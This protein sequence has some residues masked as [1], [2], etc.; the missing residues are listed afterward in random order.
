[1]KART[2][3]VHWHIR[4]VLEDVREEKV[5]VGKLFRPARLTVRVLLPV[6]CRLTKACVLNSVKTWT[7]GSRRRKVCDGPRWSKAKTAIPCWAYFGKT[8][9][10]RSTR[11]MKLQVQWYQYMSRR[12]RSA[13]GLSRVLNSPVDEQDCGANGSRRVGR[14]VFRE[15]ARPLRAS[16]VLDVLHRVGV[17]CVREQLPSLFVCGLV[18]G[19]EAEEAAMP[20]KRANSSGRNLCGLSFPSADADTKS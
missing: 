14:P 8:W 4:V 11:S 2:V 18:P 15:E 6:G 7:R 13:C 17:L 9:S 3:K 16:Q 19:S 20:E 12:E 1:M 5:D 10:Y